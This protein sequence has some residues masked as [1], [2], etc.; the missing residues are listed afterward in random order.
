MN[1]R[2]RKAEIEDIVQAEGQI[3]PIAEVEGFARNSDVLPMLARTEKDAF[4]STLLLS[5][6]HETF[7]EKEAKHLWH[8]IVRHMHYL[9]QTLMRPVGISVASLDYLSNVRGILDDPKVIEQRKSEFISETTTKDELTALYVREVFDVTLNKTI[10][11]H[12]RNSEP[13]SLML[14]DLDDFKAINDE[15]GHQRGDEVLRAVGKSINECVR[16]MDLAARYGGEELAI[17][18]PNLNAREAHAVGERLRKTI[19]ALEFDQFRVT[20]SIGVCE[21]HRRD[22]ATPEAMIALADEA[23]YE[24]KAAGK[25]Q[26]VVGDPA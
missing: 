23:L 20:V 19:A 9:E 13:L 21:Y 25:N 14:L 6:T 4:Y 22:C 15:H 11:E 8:C 10:K 16:E 24:A 7:P 1:A 2:D 3:L 5:L 18:L 17:I 12:E 26:T